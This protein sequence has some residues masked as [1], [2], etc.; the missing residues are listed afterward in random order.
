MQRSGVPHLTQDFIW[1]SDKCVVYPTN[2]YQSHQ[3]ILI[4]HTREP[5]GQLFPSR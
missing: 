4:N 5:R 1:E 3:N 2:I